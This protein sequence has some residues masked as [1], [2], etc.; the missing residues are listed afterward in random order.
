VRDLPG[1]VKV[2]VKKDFVGVVAEK[3]WQAVQAAS[4]LQVAWTPGG[5]LPSQA[6]FMNTWEQSRLVTP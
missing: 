4:K 1:V 3:Q 2:V 6:N 5:G